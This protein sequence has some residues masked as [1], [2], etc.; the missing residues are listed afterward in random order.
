[1]KRIRKDI[2]ISDLIYKSLR[3]E[4]SKS[5][6]ELL[7]AWCLEPRNRKLF[8]ELRE[9]DH[10]YEGVADMYN[11]DTKVPFKN[12]DDRIRKKKRVR[13]MKY[14][15]GVAAVL[16]VGVV[17]WGLMEKEE[18]MPVRQ[19]LLSSV[20]KGKMEPFATL[21]PTAGKV[22]YLE[23]SVKQES[24]KMGGNKEPLKPQESERD[25]QSVPEQ[26]VEYNVLTTSKQGNIKVVLY[27]GSLVWL[28]A[29]S[30]LRYPNTFV[31]NQRVVYLK[32]EAYFDV[33]RDTSKPFIV[34]ANSLDVL[35][36]GTEFGAS[37]NVNAREN[38][39]VTTLVEGRVRMKHGMLDSVELHA[40]QQALLTGVGKIRVQEVDTRYYTSWMDNMF[41]FREAPLRE[42]A[43]V[44]E[45]WYGCEC[46]FENSA[47][48][49]I[50]YTTMV[51]RYSDVDS[52]LQILA[53]TGDFH[54]TRIGDLIIIKE[55]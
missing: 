31:E 4:T 40:G 18:K 50:P 9:A 52:V 8:M 33:K 47:L 6:D 16:L 30:E 54:Y 42:I 55:K 34:E 38:S 45:N 48:E 32:G 12:V 5:E 28:N 21:V 27:D 53:G 11:V 43:D 25:V 26:E 46:R 51:E 13:L 20:S 3:G 39:C 36:L 10:L 49:N 37:F 15:S 19:V 44:L 23:D 35:V 1:M 2:E 14:V 29:G 24:L 7:E 41:A 17:L 22:V